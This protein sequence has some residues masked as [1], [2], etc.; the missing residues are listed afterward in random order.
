MHETLPSV[1]DE[2]GFVFAPG[3]QHI[4]PLSRTS[5]I[6]DLHALQ[7]DRAVHDTGGNRADLAS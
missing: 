2:L 1:G 7:D 5:K 4:R 6:E 3:V